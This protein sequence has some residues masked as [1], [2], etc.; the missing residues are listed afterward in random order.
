M[1]A[2]MYLRKSR[3]EELSDT[4]EETLKRHREM[5][6]EFAKKNRLTVSKIYEEV[7][8]GE[9]LFARPKMLELLEDVEEQGYD[10]VLCMDIDRLSRGAMSDQGIILETLKRTETKIITPRKTYDLNNEMDETYS[11]FETFLAR[12]ELKTIKRRMQ[13]GIRKTIEEGGY[14]ANAPYGYK[15]ASV[16]KH[17]TL[18]VNEEEARF[19]RIIFDLY[20]NKGM[21]CQQIANTINTMGAKPHRANQFGRTSIRKILQS[22][23][24]IGKIV[25]NQNSHIRKGA[26]GNFRHITIHNPEES[27]IVVDGIHPPIIDLNIFQRAQ[28]LFR[29]RNRPPANNGT[30]ENPLAG[31]VYC[32][33]C[34][35]LM[36]RQATRNSGAY[37]ICQK[38]EC[39]VSS[40]LS[41]VESAV[42]EGLKPVFDQAVVQLEDS[43]KKSDDNKMIEIIK[44]QKK[45]V[46]YQIG[47]L[48]DLLEQGVYDTE[49]YKTR[50][51]ALNNK[52]DALNQT[53]QS[54]NNNHIYYNYYS[55][56]FINILSAYNSFNALEKNQFLKDLI[57]KIIYRKPKGAKPAEF[58]LELY[59]KD[60]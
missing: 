26:K 46:T 29:S 18:T 14:I 57:D 17:P 21:G 2:A 43:E 16:G 25:W 22:P 31:L 13:R 23:T 11:E 41:L 36:Q 35:A 37:L 20:V 45:T 10:A 9:S 12:Q 58:T 56:S 55:K 38:P 3:A 59:L 52:L 19:V 54:F 44:A 51:T 40:S 8:S 28:E 47:N 49:T 48:Q 6:E 5:L 7:V 33:N 39:M 4:V 27:W 15:K 60:L 34:G 53:M 30:V 42:L 24:Y 1:V 32:A 50:F